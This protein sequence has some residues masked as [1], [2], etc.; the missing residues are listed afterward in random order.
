MNTITLDRLLA[1]VYYNS[2]KLFW[3]DT[4]DEAGSL[5][6]RGYTKIKIDGRAFF[7]HRLIYFIHN[8]KWPKLVDHKDQ[9]KSNDFPENLRDASHVLNSH[10]TEFTR[11]KYGVRGVH[12]DD[13]LKKFR[14]QIQVDGVKKHIGLFNSIE[15]AKM[16]YEQVKHELV[17]GL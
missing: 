16:A 6:G 10:N 4:G 2:G 7:R 15:E 8:G 3:V 12:Y 11:G 5:N 17:V 1:V 14:A 9:D 13:R